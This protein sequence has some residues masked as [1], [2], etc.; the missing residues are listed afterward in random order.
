MLRV[1]LWSNSSY[2]ITKNANCNSV[3][4]TISPSRR[5]VLGVT[6]YF[7]YTSTYHAYV[8]NRKRNRE[9]VYMRC[10]GAF[11]LR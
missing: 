5:D 9:C 4:Q 1:Y 10:R 6:V 8:C 7:G 11:S 2:G 3:A